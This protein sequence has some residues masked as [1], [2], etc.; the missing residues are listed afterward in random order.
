MLWWHEMSVTITVL[1]YRQT[2]FISK[3][4]VCPILYFTKFSEF[5]LKRRGHY[6]NSNKILWPKRPSGFTVGGE[7]LV[8]LSCVLNGNC[9]TKWS[10]I[11]NRQ[12][13]SLHYGRNVLT[14]ISSYT[15]GTKSKF[16]LTKLGPDISETGVPE[17][18]V[19]F[20][21]AGEE[22]SFM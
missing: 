19:K 2:P 15:F 18:H 3:W 10:Y 5:F 14:N 22:N 1:C 13:T 9:I 16:V 8:Q 4:Y 21:T 20:I 7:F 17:G 6:G 11:T 12:L